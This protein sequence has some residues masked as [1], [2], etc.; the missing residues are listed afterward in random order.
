MSPR[1]AWQLEA[2]GFN[3]V[4]DFVPGKVEWVINR[5]PLEGSGPHYPVVGEAARRDRVLECRAGDDVSGPAKALASGGHDFCV[6]LNDEDILLGRLRKKAAASAPPDAKVE[7]VMEIGPTTVR[8]SAGAEGLLQR[9]QKRTVP[10]VLVT[11][12]KGKFLGIARQRDL[13]NLV[14]KAK[15]E[16]P[17]SGFERRR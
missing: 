11:T 10:A 8:P 15:S 3:D 6:V 5:L 12:E 7:D 9:M 14:N 4:Y 17:V 1:A 16:K 2:L 13:N